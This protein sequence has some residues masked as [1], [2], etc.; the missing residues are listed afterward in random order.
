MSRRGPA[1]SIAAIVV[2]ILSSSIARAQKSQTQTPEEKPRK[3][4]AEPNKVFKEWIK[5]VEPILTDAERDAYLKLKTDQERENFIG[6]FWLLFQ[7]LRCL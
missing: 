4:K 2:L 1:F 7:S 3:V 6:I 5:E